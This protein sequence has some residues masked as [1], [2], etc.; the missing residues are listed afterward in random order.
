MYEMAFRRLNYTW[1]KFEL[2]NVRSGPVPLARGN[3]NRVRL[4]SSMYLVEPR[5]N[6]EVG[7]KGL[8]REQSAAEFPDPRNDGTIF[9]GKFDF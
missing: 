2:L 8:V 4:S 5:R 6:I 9:A 1:Q 3:Q 7:A